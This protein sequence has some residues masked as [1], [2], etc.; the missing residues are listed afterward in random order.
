[1]STLRAQ[2]AKVA[3]VFLVPARP[4][5]LHFG[6]WSCQF[7]EGVV[8]LRAAGHQVRDFGLVGL[9]GLGFRVHVL[10]VVSSPALTASRVL[11]RRLR[12]CAD[13]VHD[14]RDWKGRH[15]P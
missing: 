14:V 12:C 1:M 3:K 6:F 5:L 7:F 4:L 9:E 10:G 11:K 2:G 8:R 15:S 13:I